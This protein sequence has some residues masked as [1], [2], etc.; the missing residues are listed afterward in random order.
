[1]TTITLA[2][3]VFRSTFA[4][5]ESLPLAIEAVF[6]AGRDGRAG[7]R[8]EEQLRFLFLMACRGVG[9]SPEVIRGSSRKA[10]VCKKR[11]SV[12]QCMRIYGCSLPEIARATNRKDHTTVL[13]GLRRQR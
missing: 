13:S 4:E 10:E 9:V 6:L 11:V 7:R 8:N 2:L 1:M 12:W 5:T 3:D